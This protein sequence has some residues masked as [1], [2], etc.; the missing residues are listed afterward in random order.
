MSQWLKRRIIDLTAPLSEQTPVIKLPPTH[1]QAW[2]SKRETISHYDEYG[3]AFW[4]N[5]SM[6]EHTGTHF[7]A[8]IHWPSGKDGL[9][10]ASVPPEHL[11]VPAVVID[12]S[13]KCKESANFL[14]ERQH[15]EAWIDQYGPLPEGGWLLYRSGWDERDGDIEGFLNNRHTPGI[16]VECAR[17]LAHETS[18]IGV[19]VETVGT[20]AGQAASFVPPFPVHWYF[21]GA[22]KYGI[23]QLKKLAQLPP[24]GIDLII[25]PLPIVGG[26]GSPCRVFALINNIV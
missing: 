3:E 14:L 4:Y 16:S 13:D 10:V 24:I 21:L 5:I 1:G 7:D 8:P 11:I 17:W 19:G 12:M 2:S 15:V 23:T 22:G 6:S 18:I 26:T 20:D 9:D 25:A